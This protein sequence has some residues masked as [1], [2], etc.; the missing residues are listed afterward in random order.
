[1]AMVILMCYALFL[2]LAVD[3]VVVTITRI[4]FFM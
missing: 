1:M 2:L 4:E 3:N